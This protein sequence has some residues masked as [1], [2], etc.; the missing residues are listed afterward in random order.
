MF[1][2]ILILTFGYAVFIYI[3]SKISVSPDYSIS[4][5][6]KELSSIL[7]VIVSDFMLILS[8]EI[9]IVFY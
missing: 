6:S 7:E 4:F 5:L 9:V 8:S 1:A 3:I 2:T